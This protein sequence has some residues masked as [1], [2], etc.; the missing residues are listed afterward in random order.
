M[1][2]LIL[3][4]SILWILCIVGSI[5]LYK[6]E[7]K[8]VSIDF[9]IL[10]ILLAPCTLIAGIINYLVERNKMETKEF[11]IEKYKT[12][13]NKGDIYEITINLGSDIS[14]SSINSSFLDAI[15]EL[16]KDKET[17][18][19]INTSIGMLKNSSLAID[20]DIITNINAFL[21]LINS[22]YTFWCNIESLISNNIEECNIVS[23]TVTTLLDS[24]SLFLYD[25]KYVLL[26]RVYDHYRIEVSSKP[27]IDFSTGRNFIHTTY[28]Q[29]HIDKEEFWR[30][31]I[32]KEG[33]REWKLN[34]L[35]GISDK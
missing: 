34:Q 3:L 5:Y 25:N 18:K 20:V 19:I 12:L 28:K 8:K 1:I 31:F 30:L 10:S 4:L 22:I 9:I 27:M 33:V 13:C 2:M 16:I 24:L 15:G 32:S 29:V 14:T 23:N 11:F 35:E 7:F 17:G 6:W 26:N 21:Y